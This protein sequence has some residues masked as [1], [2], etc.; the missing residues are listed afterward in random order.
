MN[1]NYNPIAPATAPSADEVLNAYQAHAASIRGEVEQQADNS[2]GYNPYAPVEDTQADKQQA[3][4]SNMEQFLSPVPMNEYDVNSQNSDQEKQVFHDHFV[5]DPAIKEFGDDYV[6]KL[7]VL[8]QGL[9]S[10]KIDMPT[11][12]SIVASYGQE[13][14]DPVLEKHHGSHSDTHKI[15]FLDAKHAA[16]LKGGK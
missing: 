8:R 12:R 16:Y 13:V 7:E 14:I 6:A 9:I 5:N 10:G 2:N 3:H 1:Q 11:A 4:I 15:S